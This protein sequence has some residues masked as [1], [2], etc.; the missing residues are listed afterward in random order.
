MCLG[1]YFLNENKLEGSVSSLC[2]K[3]SRSTVKLQEE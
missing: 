2:V 1:Q 3:S